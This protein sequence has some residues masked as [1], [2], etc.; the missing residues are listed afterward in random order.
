VDWLSASEDERG[1]PEKLVKALGVLAAI[2]GLLLVA[3]AF[4]GF[5]SSVLARLGAAGPE[6][7]ITLSALL[8]GGLVAAEW[9]KLGHMNRFA[10][11]AFTGFALLV[12]GW[13][14]RSI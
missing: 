4:L 7:Y 8:F 2:L 6:I 14:L 3:G 5:Q 1:S 13:I 11:M 10:L 12:V 9:K